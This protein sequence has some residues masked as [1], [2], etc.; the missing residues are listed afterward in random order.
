MCD[1]ETDNSRVSEIKMFLLK[2]KCMYGTCTIKEDIF[3]IR[4]RNLKHTCIN[5]KVVWTQFVGWLKINHKQKDDEN[6][7][8]LSQ[9]IF[10]R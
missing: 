8:L 1:N 5:N 3:G 10:Y 6:V 7:R 2:Q 4:K 9:N